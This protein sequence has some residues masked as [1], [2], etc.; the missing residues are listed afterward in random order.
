M[1]YRVLCYGDS[2]T[3]GYISG[4]DHQRYG[5]NER[6]TR[7]LAQKLGE[8]FEIIEEGLNSRT[9]IS[10][11]TR[12]G[13]EGKNGYEYLIPCLDTH[14]PI[15]LVV[16]ILGTNELKKTYN[17][18]IEEIGE[19][20]EKY[21][22]KTI[23]NRKSQ[24]ENKYPKLLIVAPPI[25][26][27]NGSGKYEGAYEKSLKFNEIYGEIAQRNNCYFVDNNSLMPGIDGVHLTIESHKLLADKIYEKIIE[28]FEK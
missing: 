24:F 21:F 3:W 26:K 19:I 5:E 18:T 10:N 11:D 4:S 28:I 12:P 13:K 22:V 16:V 7:I 20:F 27:D 1:K 2:N 14:D 8:N 17:K 15:D 23:L 6:W 9:L 25:A